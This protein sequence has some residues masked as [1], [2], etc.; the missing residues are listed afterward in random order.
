MAT[1]AEKA[2][3]Q[4]L[5]A[6]TS[7][8]R[9]K[10]IK[11]IRR[12]LNVPGINIDI[13]DDKSDA[14]PLIFAT[15]TRQID[16]VKMLLEKGANMEPVNLNVGTVLNFAILKSDKELVKLFLQFGANVNKP[17]NDGTTPLMVSLKSKDIDITKMLIENGA[18]INVTSSGYT[19]L[20]FSI[21]EGRLDIIDLL[22]KYDIDINKTN[23]LT[24][25]ILTLTKYNPKTLAVAEMFNTVIEKSNSIN[26][27]Q[28]FY[29]TII[30]KLLSHPN[31]NINNETTPGLRALSLPATPLILAI[32]FNEID[33]VRLFLE[34]RKGDEL[35]Q[36]DINKK[37]SIGFTPLM[38]AVQ[39][40]DLDIVKLLLSDDRTKQNIVNN[41][42]LTAYLLAATE[43]YVEGIQAFHEDT[44]IAYGALEGPIEFIP[45]PSVEPSTLMEGKTNQGMINIPDNTFDIFTQDPITEGQLVVRI[46]QIND[47][48]FLLDEWTTYINKYSSRNKSN[49]VKN[50]LNNLPVTPDQVD[51]FT[52]HI[53]PKKDEDL[54]DIPPTNTN[55]GYRRATRK[56]RRR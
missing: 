50:P 54:M 32:I 39:R 22:L 11:L 18:D 38:R 46:H 48:Y 23:P 36:V 13:K 10:K 15:A 3:N 24:T 2:S 1:E 35:H 31:I 26:N 49:Q 43:G 7:K 34:H 37:D 25:A 14:T 29:L 33:V 6:V 16:I 21:I 56:R 17:T 27:L 4:L 40:E 42:G 47:D 28:A 12:L 55:G 19:I 5:A 51:I 53:I 20:N 30:K 8:D 45:P 9:G 52:A 41:D 44:A